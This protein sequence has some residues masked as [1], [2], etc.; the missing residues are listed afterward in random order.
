MYM[1]IEE[2]ETNDEI[3]SPGHHAKAQYLFKKV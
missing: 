3:L 1:V 2:D